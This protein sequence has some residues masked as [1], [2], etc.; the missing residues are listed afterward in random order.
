MRMY[1]T[2]SVMP[3]SNVCTTLGCVSRALARASAK[4]MSTNSA[5]SANCGSIFFITTNFS[6]PLT[7]TCLARNTSAMPP[8]PSRRMICSLVALSELLRSVLPPLTF[9]STLA[10]PKRYWLRARGSSASMSSRG[11]STSEE[12]LSSGTNWGMEGSRAVPPQMGHSRSGLALARSLARYS[13]ARVR[14]W[15][16]W[17]Q[18]RH[19]HGSHS[20][21]ICAASGLVK[22]AAR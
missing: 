21:P 6:N 10:E 15:C 5:F 17:P 9:G 8:W 1:A 16:S 7:P 12:R 22:R 3:T 19:S 18:L 13:E 11:R 2:P 4:S 20:V 14:C